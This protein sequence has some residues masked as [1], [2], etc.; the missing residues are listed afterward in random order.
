MVELSVQSISSHYGQTKILDQVS[1]TLNKGE[2]GCL[3]GPSGCG[4]STLLR[5]IAGLQ[6]IS[7][8]EIKL[9]NHLLSSQT[10]Q[11]A[12][13]LRNI[14]MVF[15]DYALFPHMNIK[16]NISFGISHLNKQQQNAR[17]QELLEL[18]NLPGIEKR[19]PH[20]LSG[21]QQQRISLARALAPKPKLLL[22]DEPF[23]GLDKELR[24]NLTKEVRQILKTENITVL[25]V[26]HDQSEAFSIAD[27]VGV[28]KNGNI[29]QWDDP[30][31]L[32]HQPCVPFVADFIGQGILINGTVTDGGFIN[33]ELGILNPTLTFDAQ[34]GEQVS[35]LVRPDD[36]LHDDN[37]DLKFEIIDRE[38]LGSH[39]I[40]TLKL[41]NQ[42]KVMCL[43]QSHHNHPIGDKIG[44]KLEMDHAIV[45]KK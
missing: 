36:I 37:A 21:G 43:S 2:I 23:S 12:T 41:P 14:G 40:L 8:G 15:Q 16:Q 28:M 25:M 3:L 38:F 20:Q 18:I 35:V 5:S 11:I 17:V 31:K 44:I 19:Y 10:K 45:F 7:N 13:E 26:T 30:F 42:E 39:Y 29:I 1:L 32:Y 4:K 33:T 9:K 34:K 24:K 6:A 27:T 22:M